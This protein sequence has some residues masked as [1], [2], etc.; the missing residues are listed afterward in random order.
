VPHAFL[1]AVD[2]T[3]IVLARTDLG[4]LGGGYSY[5]YGVNSL[6]QVVGASDGRAFLYRNGQMYDL[7]TLAPHLPTDW[8]LETAWA[9]NDGRAIVGAGV[10]NGQP[11]AFLA[12]PMCPGDG[13]CDGTVNWRDIDPFS[14]RMNTTC[15]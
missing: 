11:H 7:A 4:E 5:A 15:P 6:H 1:Y 9:I 3:G 13:N 12:L 14:A 2:S 10:L 8:R